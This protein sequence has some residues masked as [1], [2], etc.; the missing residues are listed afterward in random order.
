MQPAS[1]RI[2]ELDLATPLTAADLIVVVQNN[3]T[4]KST[5]AEMQQATDTSC[6]CTLVSRYNTV[7]TGA[8]TLEKFFQTYQMPANTL[9]TDGSWLEIMAWGRYAANNNN[10][11]LKL[12][13][14]STTF[15]TTALMQNNNFWR[16]NAKA[17]R[18]SSTTQDLFTE[19]N[20]LV[21]SA[22]G[23]GTTGCG[24][25]QTPTENLGNDVAISISG[26]NGTASANDITCEGLIIRMNY[27]DANS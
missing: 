7:G 1:K 5:I 24:N 14:G 4:K 21:P 11:T 20:I 13:F 12:N 15:T 27:M 25:F 23:D 22:S 2:T 16:I 6:Q 18:T 3:K 19:L 9:S 26:V 17:V 8:D 10:K